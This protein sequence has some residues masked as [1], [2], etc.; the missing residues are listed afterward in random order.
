MKKLVSVFVAVV[1]ITS[2]AFAQQGGDQKQGKRPG[3][4]GRREG[5]G[6]RR[7]NGAANG[8]MGLIRQ[9][10]VQ[11]ELKL[12]PEQK[13]KITAALP[14]RGSRQGGQ[15]AGAEDR[16]ARRAQQTELEK[17][18]SE[19]LDDKQKARLAEL[20][21]QRAGSR[22]VM[23]A[24]VAEKIGLTSEQKSKIKELREKQRA[25]MQTLA[26]KTRSQ[27]IDREL[28][29]EARMNN[30]KALYEEIGKILTEKQKDDLKALGGAP[31]KF[32]G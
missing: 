2:F 21:I 16:S 14:A 17:K 4:Q 29:R 25:A 13:E 20:V 32:R 1:T 22:A 10:E 9:A 24:E 12:T 5:Q 18:M 7:Q 30:E 15:N 26:E 28:A 11:E 19:I 8:M 6:Q 23:D 3:G 31:F 27:E